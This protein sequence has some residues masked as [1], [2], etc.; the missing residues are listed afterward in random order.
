[1]TDRTPPPVHRW[2]FLTAGLYV[3]SL[4]AL[5]LPALLAALAS[6]FPG[7]LGNVRDILGNGVYWAIVGGLGLLQA[8]FLLLVP[9]PIARGRPVPRGRWIALSVTAG[10]LMFLLFASASLVIGEAIH[11][12]VLDET[13]RWW[14]L[15]FGLGAWVFWAVVFG[16]YRGASDDRSALRRIV[17][18]L[19]VGS[20]AELLVAVPCHVY[21]RRR[22]ECCAGFGTFFGIATG[23]A[24]MLFAFGPSVY[25]LFAD[26]IE[27]LRKAQVAPG[28]ASGERHSRDA[29]VYA[30]ASLAF[31]A[32]ATAWVC[33]LGKESDAMFRGG[34]VSAGVTALAGFGHAAIAWRRGGVHGRAVMVGA[35]LMTE[36]LLIG[37][38]WLVWGT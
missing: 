34:M 1:M 38:W 30:L 13:G 8:V 7:D 28:P 32:V 19:L 14:G 31:L 22:E 36:A 15:G 35:C 33:I 20:V 4:I 18:R 11:W 24:V 16:R 21:V 9:A 2:A 37:L 12:D 29:R 3:L 10:L 5:T 17:N 6:E 23:S 26:R 27:R 25:F